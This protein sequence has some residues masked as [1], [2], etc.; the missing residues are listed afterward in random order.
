MQIKETFRKLDLWMLLLM[1]AL[2]SVGIM[3]INSATAYSGNVEVVQKQI[4][5]FAIGFILMIVVMSFDYHFI[6]NWYMIIYGVTIL[7]LLIVLFSGHE[8]KGAAR[9]IK[10]GP[11][12]LQPSEFAKITIILCN[13]KMI[14]K[15]NNRINLLWPVLVIAGVTF[16]PFILVNRQPNLSTSLVILAILVIQLFVTKLNFKYIVTTVVVGVLVITVAFVYIVNNPDQKIIEEYQRKRIVNMINGGDSQSDSYQ[17]DRAVHAIGSGG[18][19]G[20]GLYNGSISQLNYLPESHNDFIMAVIGEE[21]GFIGVLMLITLLLLFIARGLFIAQRAP[22]DLGRFIVVGYIG[23][24]AIQ[25]FVN[26]GVVTDLLPNTGVPIP[27]ISYG[28][29]ALWANK[30]GMGLVLNVAMSREDTLF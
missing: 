11:F 20:K 12:Q 22:D 16:I 27:F 4:I 28:C 30:I 1:L 5:Y 2:V 7:L 15:Y 10:V 25:A 21:F 18:L 19:S 13:A 14:E 26:I 9:W 6:G 23:M 3:A 17:T 29:S 24:I 8:A